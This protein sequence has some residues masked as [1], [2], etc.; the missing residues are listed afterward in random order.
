MLANMSRAAV[1]CLLIA[2]AC[3]GGPTTEP[4]AGKP[5]PPKL[6]ALT[7]APLVTEK[8]WTPKTARTSDPDHSPLD[9][10]GF[11]FLI[12][13]GFGD[14]VFGAGSPVVPMTID[15]GAAP[16]PGANRKLLT[17]FVHLA[18]AQL[19]DDESP[20]R[21]TTFDLMG[22]TGAAFRP[23]EA[24]GCAML[25]AAVRTVNALHAKTPLDFVVLGGDNAD[26]AQKNEHDWF[27]RLLDGSPSVECDS[28]DDDDPVPGAG[29]D[30][31]DPIFAEG[32]KV[33]WK[34]VTGNHDIENQ[35]N[36]PFKAEQ[37]AANQGTV[38]E[39][40]AR[41]W[42][43]PNRRPVDKMTVVADPRR[44]MV[45][46]A[47]YLDPI[48]ASA[49]GHGV[50]DAAARK[51]GKAIYAF[52]APGGK[53]RI[54]VIDSAA[55]TG[56]SSGVVRKPDAET[57]IKP[58]LQQ[59]ELD[60]V[61]VIVTSHHAARSF[62]DG[63]GLGGTKQNDAMTPDEWR[64][65]LGGFPRVFLHLGAHSHEHHS[66]VAAPPGGHAYWEVETAS[67]ADHPGQM[68]MIEIWDEDNGSLKIRAIPLDYSEE[69]DP[70]AAQFR[71]RATADYT[72][73]WTDDNARDRGVNEFFIPK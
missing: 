7:D 22:P 10:K 53:V 29:N 67:L 64:A 36:F 34:W 51:D 16:A 49:D 28:G 32:L 65:F 72:A 27:L 61:H 20:G 9:P 70:L 57:R 2:A 60:G 41:D 17:R 59:A 21:L 3:T 5:P 38:A 15:G 55:E 30:P 4:D 69:G 66:S 13:A 14:T 54:V 44:E 73:G 63:T 45:S 31:K 52:D 43:N 35:G 6:P 47:N 56:G 25:N 71:R 50:K 12:D 48:A 19:A 62:G 1:A 46:R 39:F 58:L 42:T 26:N 33:P 23:Q 37:S 40:G 68:R 24:W 11:A 8:A 18:D